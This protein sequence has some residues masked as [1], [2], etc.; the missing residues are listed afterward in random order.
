M[1]LFLHAIRCA[2][3]YAWRRN[4]IIQFSPVRVGST[5][6]LGFTLPDSDDIVVNAQ[7]TKEERGLLGV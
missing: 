5:D 2:C 7:G 3:A 4:H 6:A 1:Q